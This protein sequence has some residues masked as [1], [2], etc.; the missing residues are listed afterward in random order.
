MLIYKFPDQKQE[1]IRPESEGLFKV[2]ER[3]DELYREGIIFSSFITIYYFF[4][5]FFFFDIMQFHHMSPF[6]FFFSKN[7]TNKTNKQKTKQKKQEQR[8]KKNK[9]QKNKKTKKRENERIRG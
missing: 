9:E 5:H 2:I 8:T 7:K 6:S 3:G 4:I 1:Y